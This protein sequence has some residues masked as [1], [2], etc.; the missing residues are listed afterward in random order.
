MTKRWALSGMAETIE[1]IEAAG[2]GPKALAGAFTE[3]T[4]LLMTDEACA[5]RE[6]PVAPSGDPISVPSED[7]LL[8]DRLMRQEEEMAAS[9]ELA[10]RLQSEEYSL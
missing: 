8:A 4:T 1:T 10:M 6:P 7:S 3:S 2:P 9:Y 5:V